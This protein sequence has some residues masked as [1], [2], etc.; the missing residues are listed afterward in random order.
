M[1]C[2]SAATSSGDRNG[3]DDTHQGACTSRNMRL[4]V[5]VCCSSPTVV[6]TGLI[7]EHNI[8][9]RVG[10]K[11]LLRSPAFVFGAGG[12]ICVVL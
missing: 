6:A 10:Y 2:W 1:L 12:I 9:V 8:I 11:C 3:L 4:A 5:Q 7:L